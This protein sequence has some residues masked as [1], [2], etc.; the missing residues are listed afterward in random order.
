MT[1]Q[2]NETS[3]TSRQC[4]E[5]RRYGDG[6][7]VP[8]VDKLARSRVA[9]IRVEV[10]GT[11]VEI[12]YRTIVFGQHY[13]RLVIR[14]ALQRTKLLHLPSQ[15]HFVDLESHVMLSALYAVACPYVPP[16]ATLVDQS[17]TVEVRIMEFLP[18]R[19][20]SPIPLVFAG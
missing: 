14:T 9:L 8:A 3:V 4:P 1:D 2:L 10:D 13:R 5:E 20:G 19:Y 6:D 15:K 17:E 16:S 11:V 18:H 12:L 7:Q